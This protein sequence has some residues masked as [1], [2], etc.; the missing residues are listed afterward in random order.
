MT[1]EYIFIARISNRN[2]TD[3]A[4]STTLNRYM[5]VSDCM[6]FKLV[7]LRVCFAKCGSIEQCILNTIARAC[8]L[9]GFRDSLTFI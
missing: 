4:A 7:V 2:R 9:T 8:L 5:N 3:I 6:A 1:N